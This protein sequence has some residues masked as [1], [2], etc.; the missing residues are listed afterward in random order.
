MEITFPLTYRKLIRGCAA[1]KTSGL[2]CAVDYD[3]VYDPLYAPVSGHVLLFDEMQGGHWIQITDEL[4]RK[5]EMAH[6]SERTVKTGD[7]VKSGQRIGTTG[8]TGTVTTGPHLHLQIIQGYP[9]R[10]DPEPLL[11]NA[12]LA[13][14]TPTIEQ[15]NEHMVRNTANGA[16]A[17]VVRSK[18][19]VLNGGPLDSRALLTWFQRNHGNVEGKSAN[20]TPELFDS[21]PL[22]NG[23]DF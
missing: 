16:F 23:L 10:I 1:H 5:W 6:L 13:M 22:S 2:G 21:I 4:G 8:N 20:V 3:A 19:Y 18:K 7:V 11:A 15:Y 9:N 17:L 14:A 12:P